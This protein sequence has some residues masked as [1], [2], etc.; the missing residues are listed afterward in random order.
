[1]IA[2]FLALCLL[3][4]APQDDA[5]P[6]QVPDGFTVERIAASPLVERPIMAC[7]DE[8]GRLYV[9]DS[10]GVNLR[11]EDLLKGPPHRM[12]RLEDTDGDGKFD[13]SIVV[14]DKLTFPMG[15][16]CDRGDH[17]VRRPPSGWKLSDPDGDG[18][19]RKREDLVTRFGSN[20]NAADIHGP[21]LAPDGW[22]YWTDGRHGHSIDRPDG[23]RMQG[24]AARVFR[25]RPDGSQI[26]VVCGGGMDNPVEIAFTEEGEPLVTCALFLS[27]PKRVDVIF[28]AI[29]GGVFPHHEGV[30][31][32]FKRTGDLL[33]SVVDVGWVAPS[34]LLRYR[35]GAFGKDYTDNFFTA[36]F[37]THKVQR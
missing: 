11:F 20:G 12:V 14:A 19:F 15:A 31:R 23:S 28:H 35:S 26:E 3:A 5:P 32:E 18:V 4:S 37:N 27:Q 34:G 8:Q 16:L 1:M 17:H 2:N 29:E 6:I 21:F 36:Q 13:K 24:S 30:I 22:F 25:C 9:G 10:A 7:F 33:P